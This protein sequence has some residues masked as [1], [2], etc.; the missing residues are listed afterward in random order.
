MKEAVLLS[1][2]LGGESSE[3]EK[4]KT[5]LCARGWCFVLLTEDL[6]EKRNRNISL[7]QEFFAQEVSK[8]DS[9]TETSPSI[10]GYQRVNHKESLRW[11]TKERFNENMFPDNLRSNIVELTTFMDNLMKNLVEKTSKEVFNLEIT[12]LG[13]S[14]DLALFSD[15][16]PKFGML[17]V[18]HYLND[19]SKYFD[20]NSEIIPPKNCV[21]HYDPGL[22]SLSFYSSQPGLQ[23]L[24]LSTEKWYDGPCNTKEDEKN[25]GIIWCGSAAS[26]ISKNEIKP[27]IH[28]VEY[29]EESNKE[30]RMSI[31]YEI[32]TFSQETDYLKLEQK[33]EIP[34]N[35][36]IDANQI[37]KI[38]TEIK[39]EPEPLIKT[40]NSKSKEKEP[41]FT[42]SIINS[43]FS[44][45]KKDTNSIER[46]TGVPPSKK[47]APKKFKK[48]SEVLSG[49]PQ[50]KVLHNEGDD[51][52]NLSL[53]D[54][55]TPKGN[56]TGVI[57][58]KLLSKRNVANEN[59][60]EYNLG[61]PESKS[62]DD[63]YPSLEFDI[64][65]PLSKVA[66]MPN[67]DEFIDEDNIND[68]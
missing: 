58:H 31:W 50:T 49:V 18:A 4:F 41:S 3:I 39:N 64:G 57:K 35:I 52:M 12:E 26:K 46:K 33:N 44:F 53:L 27:A 62:M 14:C 7:L 28:R 16:K 66:I 21:E 32:C 23:V 56:D 45:G 25:Y 40:K 5:Q 29:P 65:V 51:L 47:I 36:F 10:F 61:V 11:L 68:S 55:D 37:K 22:F 19:K 13:K 2:L 63:D 48:N 60:I 30:P 6:I 24:D 59:N 1:S 8:K 67:F 20:Q 43:I 34:K 9:F 54:A 38:E 42:R 15:E 17:D